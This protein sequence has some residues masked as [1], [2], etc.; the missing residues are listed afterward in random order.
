MNPEALL[1]EH[2][3]SLALPIILE[4]SRFVANKAL[5]IA[6]NAPSAGSLDLVFIE[7]AA[8]LHDIG[9]S[10]TDAPSLDCHGLEPYICHGVLGRALLEKAGLPRHAL[11]C[12][13][14]IGVGLTV[15]DIISQNLPLPHRDML[16]LAPEEKIIALAD[17]F[18]SKKKRSL[19]TEK[20]V[21]QIRD[22]LAKFSENKVR[23]F[24]DWL[25]EFAV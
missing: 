6:R 16:P 20:T 10:L 9:V 18:Y 19:S 24:N 14:H 3:S 25:N 23:I 4:H 15:E 11:V 13:R 12:E 5:Q 22:D 8:L 2:F 21:E 1:S 7:E 17:L